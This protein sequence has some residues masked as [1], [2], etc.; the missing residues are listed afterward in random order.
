MG[1]KKKQSTLLD[2]TASALEV[3]SPSSLDNFLTE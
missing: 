2:S 1:K 3:Y